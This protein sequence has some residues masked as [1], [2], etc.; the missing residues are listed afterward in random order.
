MKGVI[1]DK[2]SFDR[3]DIS[4]T[5]LQEYPVEWAGFA[6]TSP[7]Q[8][9]D[10][11]RDC[12]IIITNKIVLDRNILDSTDCLKLILIAATGTDNVD[13]PACREKVSLFAMFDTMPP[14]P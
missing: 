9:R 1:L 12:N 3:G 6:S 5:R 8:T 7:Q 14:L 11:I 4:L 10:R 2:N 13:L